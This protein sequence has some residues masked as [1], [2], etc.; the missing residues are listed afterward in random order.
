MNRTPYFSANELLSAFRTR[1]RAL[2]GLIIASIL[3]LIQLCCGKRR[4][5]RSRKEVFTVNAYGVLLWL[6]SHCLC[7]SDVGWAN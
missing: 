5:H 3:T 1:F 2:E 6:P 7:L 4:A